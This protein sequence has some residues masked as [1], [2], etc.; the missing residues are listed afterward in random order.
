[1][2]D[3]HD[4]AFGGFE[5]YRYDPYDLDKFP[6]KYFYMYGRQFFLNVNFRF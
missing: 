1:V 5:Q 4:F 3:V 6:S 2:L